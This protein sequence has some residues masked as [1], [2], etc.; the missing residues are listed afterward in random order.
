MT[1]LTSMVRHV[2]HLSKLQV[3]VIF[4]ILQVDTFFLCP[5]GAPQ[6]SHS[7]SYSYLSSQHGQ[8]NPS[9]LVYQN[10]SPCQKDQS[11][12]LALSILSKSF[13]LS[14]RPIKFLGL[15]SLV[16]VNPL[17]KRPIKFLGLVGLINV[18]PL[19]KGQSNSLAL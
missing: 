19:S 4:H 8:S 3:N 6:S 1:I 10:P 9:R 5:L 11:N 17:V 7:H 14:K 18:H 12:S 13:P 2:C 16:N 15:V